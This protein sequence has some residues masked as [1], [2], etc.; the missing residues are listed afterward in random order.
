MRNLAILSAAIA[1]ACVSTE[2]FAAPPSPPTPTTCS[3]TLNQRT[4][5]L[6]GLIT[7]LDAKLS[8]ALSIKSTRDEVTAL[9][10]RVGALEKLLA[11]QKK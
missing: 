9:S 10:L 1:C 7:A 4:T 2:T 11:D 3:G 5:C 8:A 6:E